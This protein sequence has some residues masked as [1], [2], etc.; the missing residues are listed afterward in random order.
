ML[1]K[2]VLAVLLAAFAAPAL[3]YIGPGAGLSFLGSLLTWIV[4]IFVAI[5]AVLFYPIRVLIRRIR[6][7]SAAKTESGADSDADAEARESSQ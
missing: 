5:F 7:K 3:A 1:R 4:G 6:G 2:L